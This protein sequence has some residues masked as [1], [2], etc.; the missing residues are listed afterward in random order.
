M[1]D[2]IMQVGHHI[3]LSLTVNGTER[4]CHAEPFDT[5]AQVL[6]DK[7]GLTGTK[8]GCDAGDCGA[9]TVML[10]G[11]QV[12]ACLV[13]AAQAHGANIF[14]TESTD[15][16]TQTIKTAFLTHGAAQCGICTPGM[17]MAT[18]DLLTCYQSPSR[19]TISDTIGGVL[20]R[21]TG[22]TKIIEAIASL[23]HPPASAVEADAARSVGQRAVKAEGRAIVDG[24]LHYGADAAPADALWLRVIR[25]PHARATFALGDLEATRKKFNLDAILT[26]AD[27]PGANSFGV[28]PNTKDQPVLAQSHVRFRGEAVLLLAGS[29]AALN[30]INDADLPISWTQQSPI[31]GVT[32]GLAPEAHAIHAHIPDNVLTRGNLKRGNLAVGR[33]AAAV[34]A[35]GQFQTGFVEHA[36]I[37]PEAGYAE[38]L[39]GNR[40][41]LAASTQAPYMDREDVAR[42]LGI[43]DDHVIIQPTACG[44]G[45]GGK[46]DVAVQ[47]LLAI[48][49]WKLGRPVRIA[50]SR[51]ES[52][53]ST[54]KRHPSSITASASADAEGRLTAFEMSADFN[55]GAYASWGPTV[56]NRVPVHATGPYK[57]PNVWNRTRAVL[58]NDPPAGAFR[59]FGVPQAAIANETLMDDLAAAL[60]LDRWHIRRINA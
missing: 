37:E 34:H 50:Y 47:P 5:L 45:F 3:A 59:G 26:A 41:R 33:A 30:A 15:P 31:S 28:F 53:A 9:C 12:C 49:A 48:A 32:A 54:T 42:V 44:G 7:L 8:I 1:Q 13:P 11:Q 20:C 23:A 24:T 60:N 40:I 51:I 39:P 19:K 10:D 36:Y 4:S 55:T 17:I 16:L 38:R 6:R 25:S 21:C 27:V 46:L 43:S 14:T 22:Y 58:T 29:R 56:A 18:H 52:M 57:I 2:G 35:F